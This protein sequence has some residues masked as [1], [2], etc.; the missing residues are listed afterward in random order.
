MELEE[1]KYNVAANV[2]IEISCTVCRSN[3]PATLT[4]FYNGN[5]LDANKNNIQ[6]VS[7]LCREALYFR[8]VKNAAGNYTCIAKNAL[9]QAHSTTMLKVYGK[10]CY[11]LSCFVGLNCVSTSVRGWCC[12]PDAVEQQQQL[13]WKFISTHAN[14]SEPV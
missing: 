1:N 3:P 4:W 6:V 12:A 7:H 10:I 13:G 2:K 5:E 14:L 9:G 8:A 11:F